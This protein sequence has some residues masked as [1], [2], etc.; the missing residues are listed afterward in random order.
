MPENDL[1][2]L[3][4]LL[5]QSRSLDTPSGTDDGSW[6]DPAPYPQAVKAAQRLTKAMT[7]KEGIGIFGDYD[8]DGITAAAQ[9]LR[10]V[11]RHGLEPVVRLPHRVHDGYGLKPAHIDEFAEKKIS[12]LITVDTGISAHEAIDHANKKGIDVIILDHHHV[13]TAPNAFAIMHPALSPD[14]PHPHPSAAGVVFIFLHALE[15]ESWEDRDTDLA[16]ATIGTIADLVSLRGNNRRLVQEG[17]LALRRLPASPL[18]IL[19]DQ[20]SSGKPLTSVD[21]AFRVAPRI[22]AAGRMADPMLALKAILE[23]GEL[24][25][26]LD[27]LNSLRQAETARA[28]EKALLDLRPDEKGELP[29]FISIASASYPPGILGLLAGKLTERFG[30]PSMA[31]AIRG[32]ECTGS[33]RSPAHYNIVEAV[34]RSSHLLETFGGHAQAAGVTFKLKNAVALMDAL[35][36][37]AQARIP[38]GSLTPTLLIDAVLPSSAVTPDFCIRLSALEP[39]G[40][41]NPEPLFLLEKVEL[42][43]ARRVGGEG[44]HLQAMLGPCKVIGFGLGELLPHTDQPLD[45]VCRA[46]LDHWNGKTSPQLSLQDMRVAMGTQGAGLKTQEKLSVHL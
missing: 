32:E 44:Q 8:C 19:I 28:L 26:D 11:R 37:D 38:A 33:L 39:Y 35:E 43:N 17:L 46:G 20:V 30:R 34:G 16:L 4:A 24:L 21:I 12:L 40:M 6:C 5:Q 23:G 29:S 41:G 7:D 2:A 3:L 42:K 36:Q 22:N 13:L 45:I 25:K 18:K 27:T 14:I 10:A 9:I 1:E 15:G 31:V